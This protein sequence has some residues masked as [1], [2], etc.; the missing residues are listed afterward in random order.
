MNTKSLISVTE[1]NHV[2]GNKNGIIEIV[3]FVDFQ[4]PY[5]MN[6]SY[7]VNH[8]KQPLIRTNFGKCMISYFIT[9]RR[10]MSIRFIT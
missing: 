9:R 3:E 1:N 4:C 8:L 2:K 6:A 5:C 10:L 7:I